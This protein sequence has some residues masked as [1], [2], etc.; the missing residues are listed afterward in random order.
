MQKY[1][2]HANNVIQLGFINLNF[3]IAIALKLLLIAA[4]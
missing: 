4:L 2:L 1:Y 3:Y